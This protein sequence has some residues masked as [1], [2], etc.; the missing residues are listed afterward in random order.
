M[1]SGARDKIHYPDGVFI[2][3]RLPKLGENGRCA[4]I[5][6]LINFPAKLFL[7]VAVS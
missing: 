5:P 2:Q 7:R 3:S 4:H 6:L 1:L